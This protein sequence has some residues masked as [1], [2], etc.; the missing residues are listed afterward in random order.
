MGIYRTTPT[1]KIRDYLDKMSTDYMNIYTSNL[2]TEELDFNIFELYK[3]KMFNDC[4]RVELERDERLLYSKDPKRL[5]NDLWKTPDLFFTILLMNGW[6]K[7][8]D[9][10]LTTVKYLYVPGNTILSIV[11]SLIQK[12]LNGNLPSFNPEE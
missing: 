12:K 10:D 4:I 8:E 2:G 5:S 11:T 7:P 6:E 9:M 3:D 1:I